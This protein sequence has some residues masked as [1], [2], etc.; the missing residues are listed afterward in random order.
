[1]IENN[2]SIKIKQLKNKL[3]N[4]TNKSKTEKF[5]L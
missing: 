5:I 2:N 3:K 1:M 4:S